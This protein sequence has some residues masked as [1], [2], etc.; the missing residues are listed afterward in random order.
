MII[1]HEGLPRSGK[2]YE[3][4]AE[5]I[6]PALKAG[7]KVFAYIA[8]LNHE[9]IAELCEI[10][11]E[12]CKEL[13]IQLTAEQIPAIYEHIEK[14]S[15]VVI[16]ELQNFFPNVKTKLDDK[17]MKFVA[18]H[19]H[20]GLDILTM[21]QNLMDCHSVWRRRTER[22]LMF[23]KLSAT[24][25][26]NSYSWTAYQA[27]PQNG[28]DPT[29]AKATSGTR[30]YD[31][32]YFGTYKS[33]EDGTQNK[34]NHQDKRFNVFNRKTITVGIPV[35]FGLVGLG[36]WYLYGYFAHPTDHIVKMQAPQQQQA[37]QQAPTA[38]AQPRQGTT[39]VNQSTPPQP[40]QTDSADPN[41][42]R[43]RYMGH[44]ESAP[45]YDTMRQVVSMPT[46]YAC[47]ADADRCQCYTDQSTRIDMVDSECRKHLQNTVY[48]PYKK[49]GDGGIGSNYYASQAPTDVTGKKS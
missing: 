34:G 7:R 4:M 48:N 27:I 20:H 35:I 15:L 42:F 9:Q 45:A 28:R 2:S 39:T 46:V 49:N 14:D 8:G 10:T 3:A 36:C 18:E 22:K 29:W 19:G 33:H 41:N 6:I 24:G 44:P 32:K 31:P 26:E 16:D 47:I 13:L 25:R 43:P 38:N 5:Q 30:K 37:T 11:I 23:F 1:Y 40:P 12:R 17:M 21:G